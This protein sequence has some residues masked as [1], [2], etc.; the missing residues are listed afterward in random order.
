MTIVETGEAAS[1][2]PEQPTPGSHFQH[3]YNR[4][5]SMIG[6]IGCMD[7][8]LSGEYSICMKHMCIAIDHISECV[9]SVF[10]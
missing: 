2:T 3:K 8:L 1:D 9:T 4:V 10:T 5:Q 6:R 7:E